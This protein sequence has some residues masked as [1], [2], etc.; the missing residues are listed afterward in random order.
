MSNFLDD[1]LVGEA[2]KDISENTK[3]VNDVGPHHPFLIS[4][5]VS[6]IDGEE[7]VF[8]NGSRQKWKQRTE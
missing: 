4:D 1:T 8:R 3:S 7:E 5:P 2:S 6:V